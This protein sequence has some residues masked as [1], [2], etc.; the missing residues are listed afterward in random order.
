MPKR[1]AHLLSERRLRHLDLDG[2]LLLEFSVLQF[3][4]GVV[5]PELAHLVVQFGK[6]GFATNTPTLSI[7]TV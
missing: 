4:L 7:E 2:Q 6:L 5:F 1:L 3:Q